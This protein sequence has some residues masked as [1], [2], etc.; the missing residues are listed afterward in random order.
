MFYLEFPSI[1]PYFNLA[2][3][4]YV[5]DCLDKSESYFALW[6]NDNS[7]IVG[8]NQNTIGEINAAFVKERAIKVARRLS[9]GGAVY[10]D[11][12]NLNFTFIVDAKNAD[13]LDLK[14]FCIPIQKALAAL[15][16]K[17][18]I[19]GRNDIT[20]EGKKFSGNAQYIKDGRI[21]H[22]GTIMFSSDLQVLAAALSV[23]NEKIISKGIKSTRARVTNISEYLPQNTTLPEFKE[24]LLKNVFENIA[25]KNFEISDKDIAGVE[26]LA[27]KYASWEWNYGRSPN[28]SIKKEK[29]VDNCGKIEIAMNVDKGIISDM[30]FYGDFFGLKDC[31]DLA[32]L[33]VGKAAREEVYNE[34]LKAIDVGDYFNNLTNEQFLEILR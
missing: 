26:K 33:F 10:H 22:H 17:A 4:Q 18:E 8:K 28:Y 27:E 34:V 32:A 16:I 21:M 29:R 14:F 5:F 3:E 19:S 13:K 15:G 7:I 12:G 6:Q 9:G 20:I 31:A 1:N 2:F 23:D 11:L 25:R 30:R 24:I